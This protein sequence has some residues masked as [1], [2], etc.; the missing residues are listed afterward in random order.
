M[1]RQRERS[2]VSFRLQERNLSR[3]VSRKACP[4]QYRR[5]AK[6]RTGSPRSNKGHEGVYDALFVKEGPEEIWSSRNQN[7]F[8]A[9]NTEHT[10]IRIFWTECRVCFCWTGTIGT[11]GTTRTSISSLNRWTFELLNCA[12]VRWR[13]TAVFLAARTGIWTFRKGLHRRRAA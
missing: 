6:T 3:N 1:H 13:L 11:T 4:E 2:R 9:K 10:E 5:G 7:L 12:F 8:T